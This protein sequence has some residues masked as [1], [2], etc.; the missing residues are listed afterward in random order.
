M[1][2]WLII[3]YFRETQCTRSA[4]KTEGGTEAMKGRNDCP[5]PV[6]STI[7][8]LES[9]TL[10]P[11]VF[12]LLGVTRPIFWASLLEVEQLGIVWLKWN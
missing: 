9:K 1:K 7:P 11:I 12:D 10:M 3:E 5:C 2:F 8:P 6:S 4:K